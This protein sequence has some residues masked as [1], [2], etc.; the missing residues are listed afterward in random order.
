MQCVNI[1]NNAIAMEA[2][3]FA[4]VGANRVF[5]HNGVNVFAHNGLHCN[6][7]FSS[8]WRGGMV[9]QHIPNRQMGYS[10]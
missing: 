5:A 1:E 6:I 8:T 7:G 4:D 10:L 2:S 3:Y 9:A